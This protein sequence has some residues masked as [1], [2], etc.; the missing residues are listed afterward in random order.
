MCE[1]H[2]DTIIAQNFQMANHDSE[3]PSRSGRA[4]TAGVWGGNES[5]SGKWKEKN[6]YFWLFFFYIGGTKIYL[7][8][9]TLLNWSGIIELICCFQGF[10]ALRINRKKKVCVNI[11]NC[12]SI[13]IHWRYRGIR[14]PFYTWLNMT[15]AYLPS[16]C[17][18]SSLETYLWLLAA[19]GSSSP[20]LESCAELWLS[21]GLIITASVNRCKHKFMQFQL[22]D[23]FTLD[24]VWS[25]AN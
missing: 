5:N 11:W 23:V 20:A 2:Q 6:N 18:R 19:G 12:V 15:Q 16:C 25:R 8:R 13:K 24:G 4:V 21:E 22:W 10:R 1:S 14:S 17:I 7:F 9:L 3:G